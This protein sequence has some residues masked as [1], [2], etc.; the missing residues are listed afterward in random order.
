[1]IGISQSGETADTM[2][3]LREVR[4]QGIPTLGITNV[5]GSSID[6]EADA[7]F[8][9]SAGPEIGVA[10]TKS[11]STQLMTLLMLAGYLARRRNPGAVESLFA[12]IVRLPHLMAQLLEEDSGFRKSRCRSRE[13]ALEVEGIL[14]HR[15]RL[16]PIPSRLK[17]L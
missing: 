5:R 10:A 7:V 11:F 14:F 1:M 3:V 15:K 2:A 17:E 9:T 13:V 4:S 16:L 12:D 6:R 8:F